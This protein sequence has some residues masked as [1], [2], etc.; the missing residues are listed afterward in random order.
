MGGVLMKK[1]SWK[2]ITLVVAGTLAAVGLFMGT[3]YLVVH[4]IGEEIQ[5]A[6]TQYEHE[7]RK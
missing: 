4:E 2:T 6:V 7:K 5:D 1:Y 3:V